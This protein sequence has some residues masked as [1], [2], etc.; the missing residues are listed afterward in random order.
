MQSL[1]DASYH[2]ALLRC[3]LLEEQRRCAEAASALWSAQRFA[4]M[5]RPV[6]RRG[7]HSAYWMVDALSRRVETIG[8]IGEYESRCED[9]DLV[10]FDVFD[11]LFYRTVEPPDFLKR[12]S[13]NYAAQVLSGYGFPIDRDLFLYV[14]KEEE[15]RLRRHSLAEGLDPECR[16]S[17]LIQAV[18]EKL[19]GSEI[20]ERRVDAVVQ[21]EIDVECQ[22]LRIAP[23]VTELLSTLQ[24]DNVRMVAVSDTYLETRHLQLIFERFGIERFFGAIYTSADRG[25]GKYSGRLFE[26]VLQSEG[27]RAERMVHVGDNYGSDVRGCCRSRAR[28]VFLHDKERLRRRRDAERLSLALM[29]GHI[30]SPVAS[31]KEVGRIEQEENQDL[32]RIGRDILGPAFSS[33]ALRV[34]NECYRWRVSDIYF[35]AREGYLLQKVHDLLIRNVYRFRRLEPIPVHYLYVSRLATSLPSLGDAGHRML[36]LSRFRNADAGLDESLRAFGLALADVKDL[37]SSADT[38]SPRATSRLVTDPRFVE[39]LEGFAGR[40]R[41]NLKR[42][43]RQEGFFNGSTVKALV[44]IGWNAT[45]QANLTR[46]F[47]DDPAFPTLV[48]LYFGRRYG[49]EDDYAL[50]P[51]SLFL[52]GLL[53]DERRPVGSERSIN[54]CVELFEIAASAP[55]GA[56]SG[57]QD[58]GDRVMPVLQESP[59]RLTREQEILQAGILAHAEE[60]SKSYDEYELNTEIY[61]KQAARGLRRFLCRPTHGEV[62]ALKDVRHAA[63]WGSQS[64]RPLIATDL[65]PAS[66]FRPGRLLASLRHCC[67]PEGSLRYSRLPGGILLLSALRRILR[68]RQNL[69]RVAKICAALFGGGQGN[70]GTPASVLMP[71]REIPS[72]FGRG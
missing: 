57:Y 58:N 1:Q 24:A 50:S 61:L 9:V 3:L 40:A 11:T 26:V 14:R 48:G 19:C 18:I 6:L 66:I 72:R 52:P 63:D 21:Y 44:D 69:R 51:R 67:W 27:V 46:A 62:T 7:L 45:I 17:E 34:I 28:A 36:R 39:R 47:H 5:S 16:L 23:G 10:S 8:S 30:R 12:R 15:A 38:E 33:F 54:R 2:T 13:A 29:D 55:H 53:F 64:F 65:S 56:T 49:H 22:H 37:V 68:S 43:L 32:F 60:F 70:T 35:L 71:K 25:V 31:F 4:R 20:A 59:N 41:E 42:Y